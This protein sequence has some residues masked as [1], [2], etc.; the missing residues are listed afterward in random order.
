MYSASVVL[1]ATDFYFLL[2]QDTI[3]NPTLKQYPKVLFMSIELPTQSVF[4]NSLSLTSS[5]LPYLILNL[6]VPHT[7]LR[8]CLAAAQCTLLGSTM[9]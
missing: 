6:T 5:P 3:P 8:T 1:N 7:Y 4:V 9:N 2:H